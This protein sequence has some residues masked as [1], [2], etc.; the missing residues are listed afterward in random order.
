M[1]RMGDPYRSSSEALSNYGGSGR[2]GGANR[3]DTERL[4][5]ER[6]RVRFATEREERDSRFLRATTGHTRE[7]SYDDVYERRGPRG[8]EEEREHY[9]ERDY[10]DSP[11]LQ[12]E[13]EPGRQ[14]PTIITMERERERERDE[15]PPSRRAGGR[16]AFLRR[17]SSLDTF[18]RKPLVRYEREREGER[19]E[20]G[21]PARRPDLRPPP[22][23]PVPL[24]RGRGLPPPRRYAERDYEEI[25]V[26]EPDFYGDED[27]RAYPEIIREREIVRRRRRSH[28]RRGSHERRS[29]RSHSKE[30]RSTATRSVRSESVSSSDS[31]TTIS[32]RSEFPKKGK[33][34]MPARLVSKKA[35]IDL[36]YPFEEEGDTIIIQK[37]LGRENIDEVIKLS[38]EYKT[39]EKIK[40]KE[41]KEVET[42]LTTYLVGPEL[43]MS[44]GRSE[45]G[46][47]I[48]ERTEVFNIPPP[49]SIIHHAPP[50]PPSLHYAPP[51]PPSIH[52]TPPPPPEPVHYAP[53]PPPAPAQWAPP[54]ASVVYAP[55]PPPV[56]YAPPPPPQQN[57]EIH[58]TTR[59][60]ER[61]PSPA[62]STYSHHSHHSHHTHHHHDPVILEGRPRSR[63][64]ESVFYEK[65]EIIER[66]EPIGAMTISRSHSHRKDERS[67]RAEIKA[68]EAEKEALKADRRANRELR[69]AERLRR[70]GG[71]HSDSQLVLYEDEIHDG[72]DVTI[73]RRERIVEPEGGVRIEK[74]RKG[75]MSISVPKHA[76]R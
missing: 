69:R 41:T 75:R 43:E 52:Y 76:Y 26:A 59:I 23:T 33:T 11:R 5:S 74:D 24:P 47:I 7:R 58:E 36:D 49:P 15:S 20:Y 50:P 72:R 54:P 18:D 70:E 35:I 39:A 55:P 13:P 29:H 17:Q 68:L 27:F 19:D 37:A 73:V 45:A 65:R 64:E 62:R 66:T 60:V 71:R 40:V 10:Y 31:G 56:I 28:E 48:E 9:E 51:P 25:K 2:G 63:D 1:S 3:W 8:Y 4:A 32:V 61:S 12:R 53:Q 16:P 6:D 46:T 57:V 67:I 42:T 21:P 30:S 34:R 22:L 38:E 14:R 44:G